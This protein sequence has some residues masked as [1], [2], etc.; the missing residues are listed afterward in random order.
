MKKTTKLL[1]LL[2][3]LCIALSAFTFVANAASK[4]GTCGDN[5][6]WVLDDKG[7]LTVSGIGDMKNFNTAS[8]TPWYSNKSSIKSVKIE[9]G[10]TSIGNRAFYSCTNIS[11]I[12]ISDSVTSIGKLAFYGCK[13]LS[14]ISFSEYISTIGES[15]FSG[16]SSLK[17]IN[18]NENNQNYSSSNGV[19]FNKEKTS[20]ICYPS[21][22]SEI[23]YEI[24]ASVTEIED[25][26]FYTCFELLYITIPDSV[27][28][29][30]ENCFYGC[31]K[32]SSVTISDSVTT[33]GATAFASC[34]LLSKIS[35]GSGVKEIGAFAFSNCGNI[36]NITVSADNSVY[37]AKDNCLI[38]TESKYL[39]KGCNTSLIPDDGSVEII[40]DSAF[41]GCANIENV[42]LPKTITTICDSAFRGCSSLKSLIIPS[43]TT[44]I[45]DYAFSDCENLLSVTIGKNVTF[46]GKNA[47]GYDASVLIEGFIIKGYSGSVAETYAN[48]NEITF[49]ALDSPDYE[50]FIDEENKFLP[51]I[52]ERTTVSELITALIDQ[53]II[54]V[55]TDKD[56]NE[57]ESDDFVGTGCLVK[58][59]DGKEY[60]VIV[61]GDTDGTGKITASDYLNI[62]AALSDSSALTDCYFIAADTDG[63]GKLT[64][65]DYL[66]VKGY[67][68]GKADLYK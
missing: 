56:G 48:E 66:N 20:L 14:S 33:I 3:S 44:H 49:I 24:P 61:K 13:S 29:M 7:T 18:V 21:G 34:N 22:K 2:L 26:A 11:S 53:E 51:N 67:L 25:E 35:I 52:V 43:S 19:L 62:K 38:E 40:G 23:T 54:A 36:T 65:T 10:V 31:Q 4:S 64:V 16:C 39:L 63:S 50:F 32:L 58:T 30:G 28:T 37:H 57:L 46:I 9:N 8:S 15:N 5:L 12:N 17:E 47:F 27:I 60:T 55:V 6:N 68:T 1:S 59:S 42:T 45:D 41:E